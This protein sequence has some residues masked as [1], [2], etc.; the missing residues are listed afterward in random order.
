[1]EKF[2]LIP[3]SV[4]DIVFLPPPPQGGLNKPSLFNKSPLGDLGVELR[5]QKWEIGK[6]L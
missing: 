5:K 6:F 3:G 2:W 1:L 4:I